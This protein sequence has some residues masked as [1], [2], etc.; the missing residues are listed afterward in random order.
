M[1]LLGQETEKKQETKG[2]KVV[3]FL[4]ILSVI[5]L[6]ISLAIMYVLS[7]NKTKTLTMTVNNN[8]IKITE[9]LLVSTD[10]G[11]TYISVEQLSKLIGFDYV[12]GGY[13]EYKEDDN[14]AYIET[15]NQIIGY[16]AN[17]SSIY[18]TTQNSNMDN[19][20]YNLK[21]KIITRNDTLYIALEDLNIACNVVY[22]YSETENKIKIYTTEYLTSEYKKQFEGQEIKIAEE[23]SNNQRAMS[24]NMIVVTNKDGKN[25]VIDTNLNSTIGYRYNSMQFDEYSQ[26][27]IVSNEGNYGV[28]SSEG[29]TIIEL[30]YEGIEIINNSPLLY[31]VKSNNKYGVLD[32]SG[33]ILINIEYDKIGF[34]EKSSVM[35][36]VLI[37]KNLNNNQNGIVVYKDQKYG[38][39]NLKNGE[40]ILNCEV[41]KIYTKLSNSEKQEYYIELKNTEVE[42]NRYID[43][44]NTTIVTR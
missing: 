24:Y 43:Y 4:L 29:K 10:D 25:G 22:I 6:I 9:N 1:D 8:N 19:E 17:K 13:L 33:K 15:A 27:F 14:K 42:L 28:I 41:D 26:N 2:K 20:N 34:D 37:I 11:V 21:N 36:P 38:I 40:M 5:L 35:Q 16:E 18:K 23:N 39:A 31:K 12:K 44:V 3:R 30:K 7:M 32:E